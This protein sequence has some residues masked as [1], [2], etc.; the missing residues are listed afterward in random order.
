MTHTLSKTGIVLGN[1]S[2][3]RNRWGNLLCLMHLLSMTVEQLRIH[4]SYDCKEPF[5]D[6][7]KVAIKWIRL[8][9]VVLIIAWWC[10]Y[11]GMHSDHWFPAAL[12]KL[13]SDTLIYIGLLS[14]MHLSEV[15]H[16][17]MWYDLLWLSNH[18]IDSSNIL[19][20]CSWGNILQVTYWNW[21]SELP[22][23]HHWW[24]LVRNETGHIY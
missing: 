1:R 7:I 2:I 23:T 3:T 4:D 13:F 21:Q 20:L 14:L 9:F 15:V 11:N 17:F 19:D 24:I 22:S 8:I 12:M 18:S 16:S 10:F 6:V 5:V